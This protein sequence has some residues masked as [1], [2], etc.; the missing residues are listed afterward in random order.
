MEPTPTSGA[1]PNVHHGAA[2]WAALRRHARFEALPPCD[3]VCLAGRGSYR[4]VRQEDPLWGRLH[5]GTLTTGH[6]A[7]ALGLY[8]PAAVKRLGLPSYR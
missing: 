4:Y 7:A 8:E 3:S 1:L 2:S 6:L 5:A